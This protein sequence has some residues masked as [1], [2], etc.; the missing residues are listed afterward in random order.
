MS[1]HGKDFRQFN[2]I[3]Q[4]IIE[5]TERQ[6][7]VSQ[8][9]VTKQKLIMKKAKILFDGVSEALATYLDINRDHVTRCQACKAGMV[10]GALRGAILCY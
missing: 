10:M 8:S 7:R 4:S 3:A 2:R 1:L 6:A 5:D 9:L